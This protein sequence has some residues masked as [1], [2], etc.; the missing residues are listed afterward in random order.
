MSTVATAPRLAPAAAKALAAERFGLAGEVEG[1]PSERDL[2]FLLTTPEGRKFVL[3]VANPA[4]DRTVLELQNEVLLHLGRREGP[5][6]CPRVIPDREG[7]TIAEGRDEAGNSVA[8]RLVSYIEGRPLAEVRPHSPELLADLGRFVGRLTAG[9]EG[10][11]H[12]AAR[13]EFLW[14]PMTG[15]A[16]VRRFRGL[17]LA[18]DRRALLDGLLAMVENTAGPRMAAL[19]K[20]VIHNDANDYNVIVAPPDRRRESFGELRVAGVIDFGDM[21]YSATLADLAVAVAYA[22]LGQDDPLAAAASVAAG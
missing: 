4:E 16:V 15:P 12:P 13:R 1:L 6:L 20:S 5:A 11:D 8:I 21:V 14:E 7:R 19:P 18:P 2:N 10:F 9:L 17:I 3:K 22:M